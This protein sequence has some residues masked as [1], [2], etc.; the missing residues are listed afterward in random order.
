MRAPL[1][2]GNWK[3]NGG[4]AS[5]V[6]LARSIVSGL[7]NESPAVQIAIAPPFTALAAVRTAIE[8]SP[9]RLAAQNCHWQD[10]GAFTGEISPN[11]LAEI[12]CDFIIIGHSERRQLFGE[13]DPV[14]AQKLSAVIRHGMRP[15]VC[16]GETLEQRGKQQTDAVLVHQ[17]TS[18]LKGF[19]GDAIENVEIAYEPVWAIGTGLNATEDQIHHAHERIYEGLDGIFG[20]AKSREVRILYGGSV[21]PENAKIIA[22]LPCVSGL[23]VGGASLTADSFLT[24]AR[25]FSS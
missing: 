7:G 2:V 24:I 10:S 15:I 19:R 8:N 21:K 12:G 6:D 20:A 18:A 22:G 17:I 5:C 16:V 25:S 4:I 9:I 11:M 3:M 23:R 13:N 1:V 14:I